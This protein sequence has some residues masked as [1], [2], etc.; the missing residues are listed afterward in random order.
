MLLFQGKKEKKISWQAKKQETRKHYPPVCP[1]LA[2]Q[3]THG[4]NAIAMLQYCD[5]NIEFEY[6]GPIMCN[7]IAQKRV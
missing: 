7:L 3:Y 2:P 1:L 5:F 6:K 4:K